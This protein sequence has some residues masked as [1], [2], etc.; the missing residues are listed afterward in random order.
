M[1]VPFHTHYRRVNCRCVA[2]LR[3]ADPI[4]DALRLRDSRAVGPR[5]VPN[6]PERSCSKAA[7]DEPQ[8]PKRCPVALKAFSATRNGMAPCATALLVRGMSSVSHMGVGRYVTIACDVHVWRAN[9]WL[10]KALW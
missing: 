6:H 7:V 8:P 4:Q 3:D 5:L 9:I 10:T 2:D 1:H